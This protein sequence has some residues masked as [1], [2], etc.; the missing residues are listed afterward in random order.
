MTLSH[1]AHSS[2]AVLNAST[3]VSVLLLGAL[4]PALSQAQSLSLTTA[5]ASGDCAGTSFAQMADASGRFLTAEWAVASGFPVGV[6]RGRVRCTL[7]WNVTVQAGFKL[8]PGGA[9]GNPNRMAH[10][11]VTPLRLN[12]SSSRMLVE[13]AIAVD[14]MPSSNAAASLSGGPTTS[15]MLMVERPA[16]SPTLEGACST[17]AKST[18]Q[19]TAVV[20]AA[21]ASNYV[22]PWPPEPFGEREMASMGAFRMYYTVIP[23]ATT[24]SVGAARAEVP[25]RS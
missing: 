7:R 9:G 24:R 5:N 3:L 25:A 15:G 20:D 2:E 19:L 4:A 13:A 21:T 12:G 23:C 10:A 11:F 18:F 16:G 14:A 8:V 17:A 1:A 22:I 6:N